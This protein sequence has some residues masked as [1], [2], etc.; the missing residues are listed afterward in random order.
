MKYAIALAVALTLN[1]AA[2]LLMKIGMKAIQAS[3]GLFRE[4]WSGAMGNILHSPV[5]LTGLTCFVLNAAFYMY[6]L[7]SPALRISIAY[8]IMVGGGYALIALFAHLHPAL[9]ESL[10]GMQM[11]GVGLVFLGIVIISAGTERVQP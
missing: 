10:T 7:Q 11:T 4:G 8:P 5:L 6:A 1:A 9:N 2:N 3:G